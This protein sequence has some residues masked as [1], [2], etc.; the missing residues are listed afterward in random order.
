V[1]TPDQAPRASFRSE[2]VARAGERIRFDAG[3][4]RDRDGAVA[5]YAWRFGDGGRDPNGGV[6]A[7]H[8]FDEAGRYR[9]RLR[10]I[11]DERCS[12]SFIYTGATAS[13]NGGPRAIATRRVRV[14]P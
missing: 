14:L 10:V 7:A 8:R 13:C 12:A 6:R 5:R 11:D 4:S 1:V 2:R 9:V 3:A